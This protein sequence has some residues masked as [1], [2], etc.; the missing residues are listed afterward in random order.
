MRFQPQQP[1]K[2][3]F[4]RYDIFQKGQTVMFWSEE[5]LASVEGDIAE[6]VRNVCAGA[7]VRLSIEWPSTRCPSIDPEEG[8]VDLPEL[9]A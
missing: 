4:G 2:R 9:R 1:P 5:A 6:D 3:M 7:M 8:A